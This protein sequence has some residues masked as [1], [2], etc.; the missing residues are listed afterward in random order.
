M[1][2][3]KKLLFTAFLCSISSV[4]FAQSVNINAAKAIAEHHLAAISG[5]SLKSSGSKGKNF[6]FTSIKA[7]IENKDTLYYILNDTINKAF[8]IVSADKR[9]WPILGY[10]TE[11][12]FNEKK[13]PE[14]FTVWMENRKKEI[15]TIKQNNLQPDSATV[16]SWQNLSL[17]NAA[18]SSTSVEPLLKTKWDQGCYY[19]E[20]CPSDARS[21]YCGHAPTGCVATAMAQIMKYWNYPTKG[22]GSNS[23]LSP[24]YGKLMADFGSTTY[25]WNQMPNSVTRPNDAVATLMYHCG[26]SL[27]TGYSTYISSAWGPRDA[28]VQ[29]FNYSS[30]AMQVNKSG[31]ATSDWISLLKSELDLR[32]PI[33][34]MGYSPAGHSFICDGYQDADYF[35]FNWGWSGSSDG[36]FYIGNLNPGG[37]NGFNENQ[38]AAINIV[39]GN[40]P[41]GY[42]G[43]FLSSNALDIA[44]MGGSTS[45]DVCSSANWTA[46][47][48]QSWLSLSTNIG[49][50]GKTTLTFTATEN[51]TGSDRSAKVTISAAGFSSQ[52]ITVNQVAK[53]N[54]T[55]GNL[56]NLIANKASRIAHLTLTGTID[57]RD[58]KT[59]RDAMPALTTVDMSEVTIVAYTGNEGP[60]NFE[61][62]TYPANEIPYFAF[63][64]ESYWGKI[65]LEEFILPKS[66]KSI[67]SY[68]FSSCSYLTKINILASVINIESLAFMSCNALIDVDKAN[69]NYSSID[70]VLFDK[71]QKILI[72]CPTSKTRNYTIP[73]SVTSIKNYAFE[74]CGK[75][76][77][78]NIP[79]S[80]TSIEK[81]AF[82]DCDASFVVE[83]NNLN[84]STLDGVL[85]NKEQTVLIR[86]PISKTGNYVIPSSVISI[87][88]IA[89]DRCYGLLTVTIPS[90][91]TSIENSAF[92]CYSGLTLFSIPSSV[93][94]IGSDAFFS[95]FG[96]TT[97]TIPSSV[98]SIGSEAFLACRKLTNL[99]IPSSVKTMGTRA[100]AS[101]DS[102]RSIFAYPVIPVDL[103]SS[104]DVFFEINKNTCTLYVPYGTSSLYKAANQW[105]DFTNIVEMPDLTLSVL[106]TKVAAKANSTTSVTIKSNVD[107]TTASDQVWLTI[108]HASGNGDQTLTF[109]AEENVSAEQRTAIVTVKANNVP[110]TITVIQEGKNI[111]GIDQLLINSEFKVYPNPTTGKILLVFDKVPQ[112]GISITVNDITGKSFLKQLIYEKESWIDLSGN[113]PGI[114]IIKTD[115]E[116]LK[117]QK[118]ILK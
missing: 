69:P 84:Y 33:W 89:F 26:V 10:S 4:L 70:G 22:T 100:F 57:A 82:Q 114:Y 55:P 7:T 118:I 40:L 72:Q 15:E 66:I 80:V 90:S 96:L 54:V 104:L 18:I 27:Y 97:V 14:A 45:V 63:S 113:V 8:V 30:K 62:K 31:F 43:F 116:N 61:Y 107:W 36:Y 91:V 17:K 75:L 79:S 59:L 73:S 94:S 6:Q 32:H 29:F 51:Q 76:S 105:K 16:A 86:C 98:I 95:C 81:F 47:S 68:S 115:Q 37:G 67:G 109:T 83:E 38:S 101:C 35:H 108:D 44:T 65:Y 20:M 110:Q 46:S 34:Y 53:V 49:V 60:S 24:I 78:I 117:A 3:K 87:G 112:N 92:S 88:S 48:D 11:G 2:P 111:T 85:F 52:T 41:D 74:L 1:K 39:P 23:Y 102:L 28:L 12:S 93:T 103:N 99:T 106:E 25:E 5:S 64:R 42:N 9:A 21:G 71:N 50:P 56:Y 77:S 19:N 13:Q 58:F